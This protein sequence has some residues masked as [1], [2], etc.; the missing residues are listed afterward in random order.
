MCTVDFFEH[1][2]KYLVGAAGLLC[3]ISCILMAKMSCE[4]RE[5]RLS[6]YLINEQENISLIVDF[7]P[8]CL[9]IEL[10]KGIIRDSRGSVYVI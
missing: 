1:R 7:P 8:G 9:W 6:E 2:S 5:R 10:V 4:K 3:L